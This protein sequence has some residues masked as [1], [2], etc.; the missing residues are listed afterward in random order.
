MIAPLAAVDDRKVGEQGAGFLRRRQKDLPLT[1]QNRQ[2]AEHVDSQWA[3][4][5]NARSPAANL[6]QIS[7]RGNFVPIARNNRSGPTSF[8]HH[9]C[10]QSLRKTDYRIGRSTAYR[11]AERST[12]MNILTVN[13]LF[14]TFVFWL[15]ARI[16]LLP[17]IAEIGIKGVLTPILL[18]HALRHLGLMFLAPGAIYPGLAS[19]FAYPAA[20]G[21]LLTAMLA[22][23]ALWALRNDLGFA[24]PLLWI[25]NIVGTLD[26]ANA[27]ALATIYDAAGQMGPAYWI[28]A[29]W[30]P[31]LLVTHAITFIVLLKHRTGAV[32]P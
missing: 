13:L 16:Y 1:P 15:A 4:H 24:W 20:Y 3:S 23:G 26:L 11:F 2:F 9:Q 22:L 7:R 31:T 8:R 17:K 32:R 14:S 12:D 21:D 6:P 30:V 25:F 18:L 5:G 28:P 10:I 29:F 27:I 19:E